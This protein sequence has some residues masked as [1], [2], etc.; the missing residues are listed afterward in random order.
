M[1]LSGRRLARTGHVLC[2]PV[3]SGDVACA[4]QF[5]WREPFAY[6]MAEEELATTGATTLGRVLEVARVYGQR[7]TGLL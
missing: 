3:G 1:D 4:L 7:P 2:V 6:G 5:F